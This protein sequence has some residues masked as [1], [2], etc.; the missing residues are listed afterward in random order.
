MQMKLRGNAYRAT[1]V[2]VD[3]YAD[4]VLC[5]RF[6]NPALSGGQEFRSMMQ[7]LLGMEQLLDG[8]NF[9]QPFMETRSFGTFPA[10]ENVSAAAEPEAQQ[11]K[12]A[13]FS[14]RVIFRQNASWQGSVLWLE[15]RRE[16]SFRSALELVLLMN[17]ALKGKQEPAEEPV[18]EQNVRARKKPPEKTARS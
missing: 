16:E 13:T 1:A 18:P 11:G 5:G 3:S 9:P 10:E 7:F 2:C 17:S 12:L 14:V 6:Y 4:G 8:M 15:G